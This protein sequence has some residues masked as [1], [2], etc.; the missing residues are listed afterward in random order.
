M[1]SYLL[2]R[3]L[4]GEP[5]RAPN[6]MSASSYR[7][8]S[9]M[10]NA[11][12]VIAAASALLLSSA[13]A[14]AACVVATGITYCGDGTPTGVTWKTP[15]SP[16]HPA[17]SIEANVSGTISSI[18]IGDA[19]SAIYNYGVIT[20]K[21]KTGAG[22]LDLLSN[23]GTIR[24]EVDLGSGTNVFTNRF[25]GI[26]ERPRSTSAPAANSTTMAHCRP[27]ALAPFKRPQSPA[28]SFSSRRLTIPR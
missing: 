28:I 7:C 14:M 11:P 17:G 5:T 1:I 18:T 10:A 20:Q 3:L 22:A 19:G 21:I 25:E 8:A 23:F 12:L 13:P 24:G 16:L 27:V 6:R 4:R 26:V 15:A 2:Q 9:F